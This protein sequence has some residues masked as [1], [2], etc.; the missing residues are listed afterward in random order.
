MPFCSKKQYTQC[1]IQAITIR[2]SIKTKKH[3]HKLCRCFL[4]TCFFE[5]LSLE[6]TLPMRP[7]T[8][9]LVFRGS[10]PTEIDGRRIC[11]LLSILTKQFKITLNHNWAI[12]NKC[13]FRSNMV[14]FHNN[15]FQV[16]LS[17]TSHSKQKFVTEKRTVQIGSPLHP[18]L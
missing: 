11:L 4:I 14:V 12:I 7:I 18:I 10:T 3:Q 8:E 5:H 17:S 6:I 1:A 2:L 9:W 15:L 16:S 13:N